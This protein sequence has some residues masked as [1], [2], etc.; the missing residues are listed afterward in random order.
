MHRTKST[1]SQSLVRN[2]PE[3]TV[4]P[5]FTPPNLQNIHDLQTSETK[6]ATNNSLIH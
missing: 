3:P 6:Q 2:I 5:K 1:Q 4:P